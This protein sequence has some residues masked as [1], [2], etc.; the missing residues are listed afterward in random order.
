[1]ER[2]AK[3]RK[4]RHY[5]KKSRDRRPKRGS[6]LRGKLGVKKTIQDRKRRRKR[7]RRLHEGK[8]QQKKGKKAGKSNDMAAPK[9]T[10]R[11]IQGAVLEPID[12][13][14]HEKRKRQSR[15]RIRQRG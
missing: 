11:D 2:G 1:V 9:T 15:I 13:V 14:E 6:A 4:C 10:F 8:R 5:R 3:K 12:T 7:L